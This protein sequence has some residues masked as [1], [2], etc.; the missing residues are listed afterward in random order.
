MTEGEAGPGLTSDIYRRSIYD[1]DP[2]E[3]FYVLHKSSRAG[4]ATVNRLIK[5]VDFGKSW[6]PVIDNVVRVWAPRGI[7]SKPMGGPG[8][9][10][11][12]ELP[13]ATD[14]EQTKRGRFLYVAHNTNADNQTMHLSISTD[15]GKTFKPVYLPTIIPERF[16][17]VLEVEDDLAFVHVDAPND[18]GYGTLFTSDAT[19]RVFTESLRQHL[20]PNHAPVTDFYRVA[21]MRGTYLATRLNP[22]RTLHTVISHDRGASWRALGAPMNTPGACKPTVSSR[23][24]QVSS[25]PASWTTFSR[26]VPSTN[27]TGEYSGDNGTAGQHSIQSISNETWESEHGTNDT[28]SVDPSAIKVCG[29]QVSNQFSIRNRVIASPPLSISAAPGLILVHGHVATHLKNT[30]ADVFVSSDGGYTWLKSAY[31]STC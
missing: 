3:T 4:N 17:S 14:V 20:Y 8:L 30:P 19:G 23:E 18:T 1:S 28:L 16:Y 24:G 21:S 5:T 6:I 7:Q 12:A 11:G 9:S 22:D 10:Q 31:F 13:A 26:Q 2:E 25:T 27:Q 15:G 29:L